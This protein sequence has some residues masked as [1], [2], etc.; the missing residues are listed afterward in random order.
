MIG[1]SFHSSTDVTNTNFCLSDLLA[2][3]VSLSNLNTWSY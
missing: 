2:N 3:T 1:V